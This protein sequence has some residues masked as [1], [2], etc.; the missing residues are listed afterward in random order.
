[1]DEKKRRELVR[2]A[3]DALVPCPCC[4]KNPA[5]EVVPRDEGRDPW[6]L[7][8][9]SSNTIVNQPCEFVGVVRSGFVLLLASLWRA[10]VDSFLLEK[11]RVEAVEAVEAEGDGSDK[12][13]AKP[14]SRDGSG[15][16]AF[17]EERVEGLVL[18]FTKPGSCVLKYG[19]GVEY[20]VTVEKLS[21]R[22]NV[23]GDRKAKL[24][25]L[26]DEMV[27]RDWKLLGNLLKEGNY[28]LGE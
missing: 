3:H 21:L 6:L 11:A 9:C 4:G 18:H 1:M 15:G 2:R 28:E 10:K 20:R 8:W 12:R 5:V 7:A 16:R 19:G 26:P 25:M 27:V 14:R 13:L 23:E 17:V 22:P 24:A